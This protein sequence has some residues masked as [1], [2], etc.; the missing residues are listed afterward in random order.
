[1]IVMANMVITGNVSNWYGGRVER[2]ESCVSL[3]VRSD[4]GPAGCVVVL[5]LVRFFWAAKVSCQMSL[6]LPTDLDVESESCCASY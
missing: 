4:T 5:H 1:M 2:R 6:V 3:A